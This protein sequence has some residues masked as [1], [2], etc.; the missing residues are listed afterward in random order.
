MQHVLHLQDNV[1]SGRLQI[2]ALQRANLLLEVAWYNAH[3]GELGAA[4]MA[5]DA[6]RR[7]LRELN[8]GDRGFFRDALR[9][10]PELG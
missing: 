5:T 3:A 7:R 6:L 9:C 4:H 8:P 10:L 1:E 2:D